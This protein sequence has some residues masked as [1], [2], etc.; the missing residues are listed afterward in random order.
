MKAIGRGRAD[1]G[2]P[3]RR[4]KGEDGGKSD[5]AAA[6]GRD[7][8]ETEIGLAF[9]IAGRVGGGAGEELKPKSLTCGAIEIAHDRGLADRETRARQ[10]REVLQLVRAAVAVSVIVRRDSGVAEI[11]SQT[12]VGKYRIGKNEISRAATNEDTARAVEGN[13]VARRAAND[14]IRGGVGAAQIDAVAAVT[15]RVDSV[16]LGANQIPED[17]GQLAG[18]TDKN[19]V[20]RVPRNDVGCGSGSAPNH[21]RPSV[22]DDHT[23]ATIA[24]SHHSGEVGAN[25]VALHHSSASTLI[26]RQPSRTIGRDNIAGSWRRAADRVVRRGEKVYP[27]LPISQA[28]SATGIGADKVALDHVVGRSRA[29]DE[30]AIEL[31]AGNEIAGPGAGSADRIV[32]RVGHIY[33]IEGVTERDGY[34]SHRCRYSCPARGCS[35]RSRS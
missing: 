10:D 35:L 11:D 23:S 34:R 33:S 3:G 24:Q 18:S 2:L 12:A 27:D 13:R 1:H 20:V 14:E 4:Q 17:G 16:G 6:I 9:T 31:V 21:V 8:L 30:N 26:E 32:G 25:E 29:A 5:I 15:Q 19:S 28:C 7:I 22:R